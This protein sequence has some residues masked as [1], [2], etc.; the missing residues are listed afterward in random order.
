L[1]GGESLKKIKVF[2]KSESNCLVQTKCT[3]KRKNPLKRV[4]K[5]E[6]AQRR[7]RKGTVCPCETEKTT[8]GGGMFE[9]F[10]I[11]KRS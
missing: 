1:E 9:S 11:Q 4:G 7:E 6:V 5:R 10:R 8:P 2:P 3:A